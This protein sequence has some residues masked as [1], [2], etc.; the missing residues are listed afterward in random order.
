MAAKQKAPRPGGRLSTR[1]KAPT[2]AQ[3]QATELNGPGA[4]CRPKRVEKPNPKY[5][6][7][8]WVAA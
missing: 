4:D 1:R 7:P 2:P 3:D 8:K 5:F 6:G